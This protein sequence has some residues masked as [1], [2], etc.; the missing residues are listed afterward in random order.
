[1]I[2]VLPVGQSVYALSSDAY[3]DSGFI[4]DH[5]ED[6][7][8]KGYVVEIDGGVVRRVPKTEVILTSDQ[9]ACM[10]DLPRSEMYGYTSICLGQLVAILPFSRSSQSV[11]CPELLF[12]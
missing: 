9:A 6:G 11:N 10:E 3:F 7:E 1:M 2:D 12:F 4:V 5:Y 8:E